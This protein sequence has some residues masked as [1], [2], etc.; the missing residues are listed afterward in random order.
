IDVA[1]RSIELGHSG[2]SAET[3]AP[4]PPAAQTASIR[5]LAEVAQIRRGG[6]ISCTTLFIYTKE[7][8]AT[9]PNLA[10]VLVSELQLLMINRQ[11]A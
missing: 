11:I 6:A 10:W 7:L 5:N 3:V 8:Q 9:S 2:R 1:T 4:S